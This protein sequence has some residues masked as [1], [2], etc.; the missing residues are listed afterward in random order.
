MSK[1][2]CAEAVEDLVR[3][4]REEAAAEAE[5]VV[6]QAVRT[7]EENPQGWEAA[8]TMARDGGLRVGRTILEGAVRTLGNGYEG[9]RLAC[10]CGDALHYVSD[11]RRSVVSLVGAFS[12]R[13]AYYWCP[14]CKATR[15]PLDGRL[16][17]ERTDFSPGVRRVIG[18]LGAV[19]PF[20]QSRQLLGELTGLWISSRT[21]RLVCE[22][23]GHALAAE[24]PP[25]PAPSQKPE[26]L[27]LLADGAMAPTRQGWREV[28][29]G[30]AFAGRTGPGGKPIRQTTR[31]FAEILDAESFGWRWFALAEA[32]G[33]PRAGRLVVLGDGAAWIW[34]LAD[35]HFPGAV[36]IVDWYH[37][38][39][40]LWLVANAVWGEEHPCAARWVRHAKKHLANG[41]VEKVVTR[42]ESLPARSKT[43][44]T[45]VRETVGYFRNNAERMRYRRF[46][47]LG[48]FIGSGVVEAGC[49]H[50]VGQRFKGS[51]MRWSLEGVRDILALRLAV[52]YGPWPIRHKFAA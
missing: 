9:S 21:H 2:L 50:I 14:A 45:C 52:L 44:R 29:V 41:Q 37:A 49:K 20:Q 30:V 31:Y 24:A 7:L 39:E 18:R 47:R 15:V 22:K 5:R 27:Y 10:A 43:A 13:R 33:R 34:N 38:T 3:Q 8:E 42:I 23:L 40:H 11:R 32:L 26:T 19:G 6:R 51:G 48:L 12:L 4:V 17:I 16:G 1:P 46:R 36:Q 35:M 28:K 25:P